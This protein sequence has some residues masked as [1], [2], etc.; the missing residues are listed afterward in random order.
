MS[1]RRYL[2]PIALAACVFAAVSC[3]AAPPAFSANATIRILV[4]DD[5][6]TSYDVDQRTK[7][8]RVFTG[9]KAGEKEAI[10]QL[11]DEKLMLQEAARRHIE[12][13]DGDLDQEV[14]D[15]ASGVKMTAA[16][17]TQA[18]RQAGLDIATFRQFLRANM[19][20]SKVVRARFRATVDITDQDVTA[21]LNARGASSGAEQS[22]TAEYMVQPILFVVP[23]GSSAALANQRQS[24]ANSF[25]A[26]FQGCDHSVEQAGGSPGIVVRP[27]V[28][29]EE[30][31]L[32]EPIKSELAKTDVGGT[33]KPERV[34]E[35]FQ[36]LAVCAKNTIAG[37]T[38]AAVAVRE[39]ITGERGQ[40][41]ARRYLRDL[42]AD[43]VIENK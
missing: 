20:W 39:E 3:I 22:A 32:P 25:R 42:R 13:S 14:A 7:M 26:S 24:E 10:D 43:A 16:Q 5:P 12:V 30:A 37:Q 15:K 4:N 34:A 33:T 19:V 41:L 27:T 31:N 8:L 18:L 23:A 2:S 35:G 29:R 9:G 21:A 1:S 38:E 40:L 36:V 6:I 28:R 17:F 11:I